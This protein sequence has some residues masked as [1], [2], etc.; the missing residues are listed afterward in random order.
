MR[1]RIDEAEKS[2]GRATS[3]HPKQQPGARE[4]RPPPAPWSLRAAGSVCERAL[5][6]TRPTNTR[7]RFDIREGLAEA[8]PTER[9]TLRWRKNTDDEA[10]QDRRVSM[11]CRGFAFLR[12]ASRSV[13]ADVGQDRDRGPSIS[14]GNLECRG[15][16]ER[17]CR[18][19]AARGREC[20][21]CTEPFDQNGE[22]PPHADCQ[23]RYSCGRLV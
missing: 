18:K 15:I 8:T 6:A 19:S 20:R 9:R 3:A 5:P 13:E 23:P 4:L 22:I 10:D 1:F 17:P 21:R 16:V 14:T 7:K 11:F 2:R 12:I